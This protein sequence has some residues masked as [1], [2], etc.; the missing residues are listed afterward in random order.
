MKQRNE[1]LVQ[2]D[3]EQGLS[4]AKTEQEKRMKIVEGRAGAWCGFGDSAVVHGSG[5]CGGRMELR[6]TRNP[7]S[8]A[9]DGS[10]KPRLSTSSRLTKQHSK[11]L[12]A[13]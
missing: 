4:E 2:K 5:S 6:P 9:A 3:Y 10:P 12:L 11:A 8:G 1:L 13:A 7:L